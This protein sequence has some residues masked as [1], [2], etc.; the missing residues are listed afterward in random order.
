MPSMPQPGLDDQDNHSAAE[1]IVLGVDTHSEL[2]VAVVLSTLGARL[3]STNVPATADGYQA[4]LAWVATFGV[5]R[6]AGVE[7]TGSYGAALTR[8]LQA[9]G[10]TV[11]EVNAPDKATRRRRGKT[12]T[13]D[14]HAAARAVLSGR[15]TGSAKTVLGRWKCCGCSNSLRPRPSRP[16]PKRS[17]N[18]KPF[19]SRPTQ[20]CARRCRA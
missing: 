11:I 9:A 19:W 2:H 3:G 6:R 20:P 12:D 17:T 7:G 8:H 13:L 18:S 16:A 4:L 10:V 1:E 5:L 14:A 15:A